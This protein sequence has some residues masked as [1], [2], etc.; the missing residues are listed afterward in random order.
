VGRAGFAD[1]LLL[2]LP[3]GL[4]RAL[5]AGLLLG[6]AFKNNRIKLGLEI[7]DLLVLRAHVISEGVGDAGCHLLRRSLAANLCLLYTIVNRR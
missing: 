1:H 7:F 2:V 4:R 3:S 6:F 5:L